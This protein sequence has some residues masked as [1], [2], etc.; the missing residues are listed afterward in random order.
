MTCFVGPLIMGQRTV[1][2]FQL[3]KGASELEKGVCLFLFL[4]THSYVTFELF[5]LNL[6]TKSFLRLR[7]QDSG[8]I[9]VSEAALK[10]PVNHFI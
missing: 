8:Q 3:P 1:V 10:V 7:W 2:K 4:V 5:L 6:K 9:A